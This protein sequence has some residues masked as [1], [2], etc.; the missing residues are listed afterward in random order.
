MET[1]QQALLMDIEEISRKSGLSKELIYRFTPHGLLP[2]PSKVGFQKAVYNEDHLDRL[3]KIKE[4]REES[5]MPFSEIRDLLQ[6]GKPQETSRQDYSQ[7][8]KEQIMDKALAIFRKVAIRKLRSA[9]LPMESGWRKGPSTSISRAKR[10][11]FVEC[12]SRLTTIVLPEEVLDEIR[13]QDDFT[14]RMRI[15]LK[16]FLKTFPKF[17]G[18]LSLLRLSLQSDDAAIAAKARETYRTLEEP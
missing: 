4:F 6:A 13:R 2:R 16:A 10:D 14:E 12:M 5:K 9:I 11:L 7:A 3:K 1:T 18:V 8:K 15:K 17:A